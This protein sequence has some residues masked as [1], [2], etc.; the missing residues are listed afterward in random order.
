MEHEI[1]LTPR[2]LIGWLRA[3]LARGPAAQLTVRATREF[4][5]EPA[6]L[7]GTDLDAEDE[8]EALTTVGL[9]EVTPRDGG[10]HWTLRLRVEDALGC[11]LPEDGSVPDGP[12]E[13]A[14]EVFADGF[15]T[16]GEP[17]AT[18][19]LEA[20]TPADRRR[21]ERVLARMLAD[22]HGRRA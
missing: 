21:F 20:A 12:E 9:V 17:D 11:H 14:L 22:R 16:D 8:M 13:I 5:G 6:P 10:G 3:D 4:F 15:L 1:D 18:I 7:A 2:H 19:T